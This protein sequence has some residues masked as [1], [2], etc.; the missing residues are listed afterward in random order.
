MRFG[1]CDTEGAVKA[2]KNTSPCS[3]VAPLFL[4]MSGK[5][6]PHAARAFQIKPPTD[7]IPDPECQ[8]SQDAGEHKP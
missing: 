4:L 6:T 7:P 1:T 2:W 8:A 5:P 3:W